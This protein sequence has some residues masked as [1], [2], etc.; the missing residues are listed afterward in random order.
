MVFSFHDGVY[1][2]GIDS[3]PKH[4]RQKVSFPG[5]WIDEEKSKIWTKNSS[6]SLEH[7]TA[8]PKRFGP[9][10]ALSDPHVLRNCQEERF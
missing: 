3:M 6:N 8:G 1:P 10:A 7:E 2:K 9:T 4:S 5:C